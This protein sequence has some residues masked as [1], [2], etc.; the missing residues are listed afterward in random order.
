MTAPAIQEGRLDQ[1]HVRA[2]EGVDQ[3]GLAEAGVI[4]GKD[5]LEDGTGRRRSDSVKFQRP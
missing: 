2:A 5:A 4:G 1:R 3:Q